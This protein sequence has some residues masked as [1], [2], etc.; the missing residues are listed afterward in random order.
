MSWSS[1]EVLTLASKA[2]RGAGAPPWQAIEFGRAALRHLSAGRDPAD[3][4]AALAALPGGPILTLPQ[5]LAELVETGGVGE[6]AVAS[7]EIA[8][9]TPALALSYLEAR[10]FETTATPG[11]QGIAVRLAVTEPARRTLPQRLALPEEIAARLEAL[12]ARTY[13]PESEASRRAGAGA[14]LT[15]N[16]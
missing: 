11:A 7:G 5:R 8:T 6:G 9:D 13:V 2:A 3:L 4:V 15:D 14:G 1:N 16:D 10:P 12:A